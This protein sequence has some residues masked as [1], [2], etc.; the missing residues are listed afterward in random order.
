MNIAK[1]LTPKCDVVYL[2]ADDTVKT[3]MKLLRSSGFSS[4]PVIS[5]DGM[6][7]GS[8]SEGDFLWFITERNE[9]RSVTE[10]GGRPI[11]EAVNAERNAPI[12]ITAT[13]YELLQKALDQNFVPVVDDRGAFVG[14]VTRKTL[15]NHLLSRMT[16]G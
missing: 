15:I 14:I 16:E 9:N 11:S 12:S 13:S 5:K 1:L 10:L 7:A 3:G 6:Y 4:I 8:V 2:N